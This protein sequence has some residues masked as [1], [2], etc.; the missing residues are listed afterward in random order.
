MHMLSDEADK[1]AILVYRDATKARV[2]FQ[3]DVTIERADATTN[4]QAWHQLAM[5]D[6][7][8]DVEELVSPQQSECQ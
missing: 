5:V 1:G 7:Q 6:H 4:H 3:Q 8:S 2:C